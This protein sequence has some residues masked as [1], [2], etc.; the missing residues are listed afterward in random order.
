MEGWTGVLISTSGLSGMDD[1]LEAGWKEGEKE[2]LRRGPFV[3][4]REHRHVRP[5]TYRH[6][7]LGD[8]HNTRTCCNWVLVLSRPQCSCG[9]GKRAGKGRRGEARRAWID[10]GNE[11]D[12]FHRSAEG[13]KTEEC[14]QRAPCARFARFFCV[15][16][17]HESL[18]SI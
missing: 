5:V 7:G 11:E 10:R 1:R 14:P 18:G 4:S 8:V 9:R 15:H 17:L 12:L 16:T 6:V 2:D 13:W 3:I